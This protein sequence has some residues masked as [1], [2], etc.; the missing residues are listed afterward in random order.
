MPILLNLSHWEAMLEVVVVT[1]VVKRSLGLQIPTVILKAHLEMA[2][3][4]C[5]CQSDQWGSGFRGRP[6]V[7]VVLATIERLESWPPCWGC[8]TPLRCE[9]RMALDCSVLFFLPSHSYPYNSLSGVPITQLYGGDPRGL[10]I[11]QLGL[12]QDRALP[13]LD[14]VPHP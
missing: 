1:P 7:R 9:N 13:S 8:S 11:C 14:C 3:G 4:Y 10:T 6:M 2:G 5:S 12:Q